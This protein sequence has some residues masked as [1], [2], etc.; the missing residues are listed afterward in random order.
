MKISAQ[1]DAVKNTVEEKMSSWAA[2]VKKNIA[3]KVTQKEMNKIG[4]KGQTAPATVEPLKS[5]L[6][7]V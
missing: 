5:R 4:E 7:T 3:N 1:L 6:R 2:V